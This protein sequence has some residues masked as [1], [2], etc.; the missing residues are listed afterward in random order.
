MASIVVRNLSSA[1]HRA[2][3]ARAR[4]QGHSMEAEVRRILDAAVEP[5]T[6][7]GALLVDIAHES[8]GIEIE[9][10]RTPHEPV[11]LLQ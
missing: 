4:A 5:P 10:D 11:D 1:T 6:R 9:L 8:G 7:L 2:L 3:K